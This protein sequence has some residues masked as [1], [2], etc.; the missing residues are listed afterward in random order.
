MTFSKHAGKMYCQRKEKLS[1][2]SR[3][4][5]Y[6]FLSMRDLVNLVS[7]VSKRDRKLI[8]TRDEELLEKRGPL[9]IAQRLACYVFSAN[10]KSQNFDI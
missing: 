8:S 9:I 10:P 4:I 3:Y 2:N 5:V 7:K 1:V 6:S